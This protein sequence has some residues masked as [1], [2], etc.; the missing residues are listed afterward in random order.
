MNKLNL[1]LVTLVTL[2]L[3]PGCESVEPGNVGVVTSWN[4]L[5][6]E[7][8]QAGT[9]G[10]GPGTDIHSMS[11]RL[12]NVA[13]DNIRCRSSDNVEVLVD[14]TVGVTLNPRSAV[15]VY[16]RLGEDYHTL[17]VIPAIRS[18]VR[19]IVGHSV[20]LTV[21]QARAGLEGQI[22]TSVQAAVQ[23][24]LRKR[25]LDT[26]ALQIDNVQLRQADLPPSL[27]NSIESVQI[28][29]NAGLERA[30]AL[31]TARQEAARAQAEAEGRNAVALINARNEAEIRRI[32]GESQAAFNRTMSASLTP[33]L[34]ELRRIQ[35]QL[36]GQQAIARNTNAQLV[37]IPSSGES[38][39]SAPIVL[40]TPAPT[41]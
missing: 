10:V 37:V 15:K 12:Q 34:I 38:R 30:Q 33:G 19:D 11:T 20:A 29:R 7:V 31:D 1:F 6:G 5:T 4:A 8:Y 23:R 2:L 26:N 27:R 36:E 22:L 16:S 39:S 14:V 28:Q 24:T 41:R 17:L 32:N 9:Y 3:V 21:A 35:A 25:G 13:E 18:S 40:T